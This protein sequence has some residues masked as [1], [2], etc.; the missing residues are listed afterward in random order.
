MLWAVRLSVCLSVCLLSVT[1]VH[2]T[3]AVELFGNFQVLRF[4]S[5]IYISAMITHCRKFTAKRS[6]RFLEKRP[7]MVIFLKIL[8][9]K[10]TWRH[11]SML[12]CWNV[13]KLCRREI[14]EIV[15]Y[16]PDKKQ[17]F[18]QTVATK[19]IAP[20]VCQG[21]PPTHNVPNFIQNRFTFGGVMAERV[22]A[23]FW[24]IE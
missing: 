19:R 3:Q 20:K 12:L 18:S 1:L 8:L 6:L 4:L 7:L 22:T 24:P 14:A 23:V 9:R 17:N 11:Q 13:V 21:Q 15:R 5:V 2:P 10:F 16:L